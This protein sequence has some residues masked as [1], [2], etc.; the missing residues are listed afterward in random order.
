MNLVNPI[1]SVNV[2]VIETFTSSLALLIVMFSVFAVY[3]LVIG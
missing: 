2:K 3:N 1:G